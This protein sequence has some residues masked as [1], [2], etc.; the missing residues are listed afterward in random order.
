MED[1]KLIIEKL[2]KKYEH[3]DTPVKELAKEMSILAKELETTIEFTKLTDVNCI[4]DLLAN[5]LY[6]SLEDKRGTA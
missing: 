3:N 6:A 1:M 5:I 2:I 4:R